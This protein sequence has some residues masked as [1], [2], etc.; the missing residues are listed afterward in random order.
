MSDQVYEQ[1]RD[2][3]LP[4]L[5][6]SVTEATVLDVLVG[7]GDAVNAGDP[8]VEV[9]TDKVD[10]EI[11]SPA[12]G[13]VAE[14]LVAAGDAVAVGTTVVRLDTAAEPDG[15]VAAADDEAEAMPAAE[16]G[17]AA[18]SPTAPDGTRAAGRATP[19]AARMAAAHGVPAE[20]IEGSG[21][22]GTVTKRDV[23]RHVEALAE[24]GATEADAIRAPRE[25]RMRGGEAM[26]VRYMDES[27]TVPTA[28]TQREVSAAVLVERRAALKAAGVRLS[29]THLIAWALVRAVSAVPAMV[30]R[31]AERDGVPTRIDDG[32]VNLGIAVDVRRDD[33]T[34][35]VLV[36]VLR[37]ADRLDAGGFVSAYDDLVARTRA[38]DLSPDDLSGANVTLTNTGGFGSTTGMPRLLARQSAIIAAGGIGVPASL[39]HLAAELGVAPTM[40]LASTY[41]H[42]VIQGADSGRFLGAVDALLQ[43]EH[44]FYEE[45][46]GSLGVP[47]PARTPDGP[48]A[49]APT[50]AA[51]A[52]D[53]ER[54]M[55]TAMAAAQLLSQLR[56]R[57]HLAAHLDPLSP[58]PMLPAELT[59][60]AHGTDE[61]ALRTVPAGL[62]GGDLARHGDAASALAHLREVYCGTTGYEFEHLADPER[63]A[64][65]RM[66]VERR[67]SDPLKPDDARRVLRRLIEVDDFE[68]YLQ[69][70]WLGQKTLSV[71]GLDV[72]VP[73]VEEL[74]RLAATDRDG[75]VVIGM[76]HRGRLALLTHIVGMPLARLFRE[77]DAYADAELAVPQGTTGDVKQHLGARGVYGREDGATIAVRLQPNPS[78]L[79]FVTPVAL[80]V[81]RALR[82][83]DAE[84]RAALPI[85]LHGDA[86]F[87]GQ[88]VVTETFNLARLRAYE[89][90]GAVH[91][92]QNNQIGFTTEPADGR[93]ST[94]PTDAARGS[95]VP[96]LHVNAE[97]VDAC[98]HAVRLARAYQREFG[99][100]VILDVVGYRRLGHN[101]TDEPAFTQPRLY[102]QIRA[103]P[104]LVD[105]YAEAL[106][107]GGVASAAEVETWRAES[108][109]RLDDALD[110]SRAAA[111]VD[112]RPTAEPLPS[113][114]PDEATLRRVNAAL[115]TLPD[116]FTVH[117][118]LDALLARRRDA[119]VDPGRAAIDWGHAEALALAVAADAGIHVRL[120]G[121]DT[122]RGAFTQRHLVLHDVHDGRRH[123]PISALARPGCVE[124]INSPLSEQAPVGYEWGFSTALPN[125]LVLWE[126]QFGDFANVAQTVV[127][128]F[129]S[130]AHAK[131]G[132]DSGLVLLLPHGYEGAGP[133]HSSA[134]LER[135]L[136]LSAEE[137]LRVAYPTTAAQHYHLLLEQVAQR[138][139]LVVMTPKSLLRA[140]EAA[141]TP[142]ELVGGRFEPVLLSGDPAAAERLLVCTGKVGHDLLAAWSGDARVAIVR[143]E[144]LAPF[145]TEELCEVVTAC[146]RLRDVT[147][148]QEEPRNM[149]AWTYI[150]PRVAELLPG[151]LTLRYV[152]RPERA[153]PAEGY[154]S[155]HAVRQRHI[156]TEALAASPTGLD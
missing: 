141:A 140:P 34:S 52:V 96:V 87:P 109:Q 106:I 154:P 113:P 139:P 25:L 136:G 83:A 129:V 23:L 110:S 121:E 48:R 36:P 73:M 131:W 5:G 33:G 20:A 66:Q 78:H 81:A 149:G 122:Q 57:G 80:G 15:V 137:G 117:R 38:G 74:V 10:A 6:E 144:R 56:R 64:W 92:V 62:L 28:T 111:P 32:A 125:A 30:H 132:I 35:T 107:A 72:T 46:F 21:R 88:G 54:A 98:L 143:L 135:Y 44:G 29:Y 19:V 97:D 86:S 13:T 90:G 50:R 75:E 151:G 11:P 79:E 123:S 102:E 89:V 24:R 1:L 94:Y 39:R 145:P 124:I 153:A 12:T 108:R 9:S 93:G 77:F 68:R 3:E 112:P 59:P 119:L 156:V 65:W 55:S 76:A 148:V 95:T 134:R 16:S 100:D 120:S 152:G 45:V 126:A 101:E 18:T 82:T 85:L 150:A 84:G 69:R 155:L 114:E 118:K 61:A 27:R 2:V 47:M 104:R 14:V 7:P 105:S 127:D 43:G 17:D 128:N 146:P 42:R 4:S 115:H 26:L 40:W 53:D 63:V 142:R 37:G 8:L 133:E 71:E 41:D 22:A 99:D 67:R 51:A 116:G 49:G 138:R 31:F 91:I 58:A 70:T 60:A 103:R 147:W 130:A